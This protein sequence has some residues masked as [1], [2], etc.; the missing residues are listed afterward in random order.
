M[1]WLKGENYVTHSDREMVSF[2]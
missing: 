1:R 2:E